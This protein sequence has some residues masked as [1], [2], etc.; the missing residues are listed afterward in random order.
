[1]KVIA[2]PDGLTLVLTRYDQATI[3]G[4]VAGSEL[5]PRVMVEMLADQYTS[6]LAQDTSDMVK[7]YEE[8]EAENGTGE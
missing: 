5:S 3:R 8:Q 4:S 2:T 6:D 7:L 1:M